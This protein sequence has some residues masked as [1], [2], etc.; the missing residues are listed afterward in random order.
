[1][2]SQH[3]CGHE[4]HKVISGNTIAP[5]THDFY[6][7]QTLN[8]QA[9]IPESAAPAPDSLSIAWSSPAAAPAQG[10]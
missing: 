1:M 10:R 4:S 9:Q 7:D 5:Q 3:N 2:R 8:S 6:T